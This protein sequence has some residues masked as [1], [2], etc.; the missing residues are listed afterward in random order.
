MIESATSIQQMGFNSTERMN[1]IDIKERSIQRKHHSK[2]FSIS[3]AKLMSTDEDIREE[4]MMKVNQ[5]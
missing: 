2:P 1:P 5:N 4:E 3:I